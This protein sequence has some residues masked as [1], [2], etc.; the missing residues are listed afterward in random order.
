MRSLALTLRGIVPLVLTCAV[1]PAQTTVTLSP[2][3]DAYVNDSA[4]TDNFNNAFLVVGKSTQE[5]LPRYRSFLRF[6]L[7][8]IPAGA[9]IT[10]ATLRLNL[11]AFEGSGT[12]AIEVHRVLATWSATTITWKDQPASDAAVEV[13]RSPGTSV[14]SW[15]NFPVTALVQSWVDGTYPSYGVVLKAASETTATK[16]RTFASANASDTSIRPA[17]EVTYTTATTAPEV[18]VT[19]ASLAFGNQAVGTTSAAQAL[20]VKNEGTGPLKV[21]SVS[22]S[23]AQFTVSG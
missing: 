23:S 6:N 17:M 5:F 18:Q 14:G 8:S 9:V 20:R 7:G 22:S 1:A 21:S 10:S 15:Y 4:L 13:S 16:T 3:H 12:Q 11:Q 19:P 2:S